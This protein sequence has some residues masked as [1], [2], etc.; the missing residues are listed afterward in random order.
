MIEKEGKLNPLDA[1]IKI[2]GQIPLTQ[3]PL[4]NEVKFPGVKV[5]LVSDREKFLDITS[6]QVPSDCVLVIFEYKKGVSWLDFCRE[7]SRALNPQTS[8]RR[9]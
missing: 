9:N 2:V 6:G 7:L 8:G 4:I 5:T 1:P 3:V